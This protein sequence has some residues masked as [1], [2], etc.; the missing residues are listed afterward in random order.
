M[1]AVGV[2]AAGGPAPGRL[3]I[4]GTET[5]LRDRDADPLCIPLRQ[6]PIVE[7]NRLRWCAKAD[8]GRIDVRQGIQLYPGR[9][10]TLA[11]SLGRSTFRSSS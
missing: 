10:S 11:G 4:G 8:T 3:S 9:H 2:A 7:E 5:G 1:A 6:E